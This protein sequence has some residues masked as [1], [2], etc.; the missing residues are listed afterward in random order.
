L[1]MGF[2]VT[3]DFGNDLVEG[4][5]P[6]SDGYMA[7]WYMADEC[8]EMI[9][10]TEGHKIKEKKQV[11]CP[12][13][14]AKSKR[15]GFPELDILEVAQKEGF[16]CTQSSGSQVSGYFPQLGSST[17]RNVVI[18]IE[19]GVYCWMHDGINTGGDVWVLL[20]HLSGVSP[21]E[22]KGA[23][24][25]ND[26][27]IKEVT[28]QYAIFR[29][30]AK[31]DD[32]LPDDREADYARALILVN[33]LG[34]RV[35]YAPHMG[36]W[37]LYNGSKWEAEEEEVLMKISSDILHEEYVSELN[38]AKRRGAD[39]KVIKAKKAKVMAANSV[40][41]VK[42][43][44]V[45]LKGMLS[46]KVEEWDPN[47]W[48]LNVKNGTIDLQTGEFREHRPEDMITLMAPI[49]YDPSATSPKWDK[50]LEMFLPN[51]N[52]RRQV[53][54]DVGKALVGAVLEESLDVWYGP[55][56][57]NGKSTTARAIMTLL[58]EYTKKAAPK[59]LLQTEHDRHP[60][61]IADLVG[62]RIVFSIEVE[63]GSRLAVALVK[64]LTGGDIKKA[65]FMRQD[66]FSFT[67]TFDFILI[68]NNQ[69]KMGTDE[70]LWRRI[71]LI[72][73]EVQLPLE[74]RR[75]QDDVINEFME[76]GPG[77]LNWLL[78]GLKDWQQDPHWGAPEVMNATREWKAEEDEVENFLFDRY[79][80][81]GKDEDK[82]LFS[83]L[84][85]DYLIWCSNNQESILSKKGFSGQLRKK[86][87]TVN[88]RSSLGHMVY[89]LKPIENVSKD[90][91]KAQKEVVEMVLG[92]P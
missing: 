46:T 27:L 55:S 52:I 24:L 31:P 91:P 41:A 68:V 19:K 58:G 47:S 79:E 6:A 14:G 25:M 1:R 64:D 57:A 2:K 34:E 50:H 43:A 85:E 5:I 38:D 89:G 66:F 83:V 13:S 73:W 60:T 10:E 37:L 92:D 80:K 28:T 40:G 72:P 69:P 77:I 84:Y 59:L 35:R 22:E 81:T 4:Y 21:W 12:V 51:E 11:S 90:A 39:E 53:Q 86:G 88:R 71:K 20:A 49:E 33:C 45:F 23:G 8:K 76:E 36:K 67:Q 75:P 65:R 87:L 32:F 62:T 54:R 15:T 26:P 70:A 29:G 16:V 56:G 30:Y 42:S 9:W 74:Q 17:G 78:D 18:D 82:I 7:Q 61:E 63:E 3:K 48:L 44:L